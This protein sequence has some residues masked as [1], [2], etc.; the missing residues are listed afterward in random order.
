MAN[1]FYMQNFQGRAGQTARADH[2]TTELRGIETAFDQLDELTRRSVRGSTGETLAA[3]PNAL[4]R[5]GRYLRF[6]ANGQPEAVQTGFT[7]RGAHVTARLYQVGD[8]VTYGPYGSLYIAIGAHT[9]TP[10]ISPTNFQIMID[11]TGLNVIKNEIRTASF[12]AEAG[13]DYLI[14]SIGGNVNITLPTVASILDPPINITHL[15]GSLVGAQQI[16]IVRN[17]HLIMGLAENMGID[18][19]NASVSFMYSNPTYGYRL[20]V[21]A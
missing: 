15:A 1:P 20:R 7:W 19:A 21:L 18:K 9:S 3:L 13:G 2:V 8:V 17:G 14:N 5:A 11:L 4:A 16:N 10:T 12:T 6:D